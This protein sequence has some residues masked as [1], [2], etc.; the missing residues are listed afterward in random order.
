MRK[1]ALLSL[2]VGL[3]AAI[4]AIVAAVGASQGQGALPGVHGTIWAVERFDTGPNTLAALDA[5][6]GEVLGVQQ[7]GKR[8]I[9]VTSPKGT[10]RST[11]RMN[12][13]T[14]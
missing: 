13:A 7:V 2:L 14:S 11:R 1:V 5:A 4:A 8:P 12:A 10:A 3:G 6:T 9:G